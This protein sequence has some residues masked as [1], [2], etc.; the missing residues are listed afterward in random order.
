[1]NIS[2]LARKLRIPMESLREALPEMGF[3][4]GR[5]AIKIDNA[6][7]IKIMR[8]WPTYQ[9]EKERKR[10]LLEQEKTGDTAVPAQPKNVTLP[11]IV[12][13]R[14]F[15]VKL[16][17]PVTR[18]LQTL[19][20]NGI[21][22]ALNEKLD[23]DTASIIAEDLGYTPTKESAEA[24]DQSLF[25]ADTLKDILGQEDA[26]SLIARPPVVVVM[27]HVDHGKTSLLDAIR[28][29]QVTASESGGITQHIGA[30]Q[31][32][33]T[34]KKTGEEKTLTFI[35][36]PGHEAF[37]TMRS[38]GAK[39][40][41]IAILVV[42]ADDGVK[43][44]TIEAIK[45]I[46]AAGLPMIVA[47]NKIDKPGA[48][49][50]LV[51]RELSDNGL[52]PEDWGGNTVCAPLS[53][54]Q[55]TG[56][57]DLLEVVML[58]AEIEKE[59]IV[60][61]PSG[62]IVGTVIESHI[63]PNE[64][65]VATVLVQ[66]GTLQQNYHL[67]IEGVY[68]GK[69]RAMRDYLG[70]LAKSAPPSC[71]VRIIGFKYAPVI[72]YVV[73][74]MKELDKSIEKDVKQKGLA[75]RS[76]VVSPV[77]N[78]LKKGARSVNVILKTDTLGSLE[79]IANALLKID[80]P[81]V[82]VAIVSKD[83]G[84]ITSADVLRA[85]A[86]KSFVAGFHVDSSAAAEDIAREKDVEIKKYKVIYDLIDDVKERIEELLAPEMNR[87]L[88]G[89]M[90]VLKVFRKETASMIIGGRVSEGSVEPGKKITVLR[91]AEIIG[92]GKITRVQSGKNEIPNASAGQECGFSID[93]RAPIQEGDVI[94]VFS[95]ERKKRTLEE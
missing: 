36:T 77:R 26:A 88:H 22:T 41:D 43:P 4:V 63:D 46:K 5:R 12:T 91:N 27:G 13:V 51:K 30:Y 92:D 24:A 80:H 82:K 65:P 84:A 25:T 33:R 10:R 62:K 34:M 57:E 47:I 94:E 85:E 66:N 19:M 50:D 89:T 60:A 68:A 2:E 23:Y 95:I 52:I 72:G 37:T 69:V 53:A 87:V 55:G 9:A 49:L 15:A 54:K 3:D 67:V 90:T 20:N 83:L 70:T 38:R 16:N 74:G 35:D 73:Q 32:T 75:G 29:T 48:N 39:I 31:V 56:I 93:T 21:L 6:T 1:M 17:I 61:N 64:G 78:D 86:T 76:V 79:A 18:L 42:A 28:K 45:I 14:D 71:P 8:Q 44:Q 59:K 7:A 81:E 40:A 58:V 11:A